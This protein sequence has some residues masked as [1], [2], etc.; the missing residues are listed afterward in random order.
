V[1]DAD[2]VWAAAHVDED[3]NA[4]QWGTDEEAVR[5]R[6]ARLVDFR[7]AVQILKA[8]AGKGAGPDR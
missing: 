6:E 8:V 5:A 3:W 7:A 2:Q 4:E 1:R